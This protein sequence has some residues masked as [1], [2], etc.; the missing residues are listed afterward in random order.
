LTPGTPSYLPDVALLPVGP[1]KLLSEEVNLDDF[2]GEIE[3]G[4][5][6]S[7]PFCGSSEIKVTH[8]LALQVPGVSG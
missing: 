7:C 6:A 1:G 4:E 3:V 8:D 5:P 2:D